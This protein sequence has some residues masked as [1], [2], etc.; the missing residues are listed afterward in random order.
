MESENEQN[1]VEEGEE[2]VLCFDVP[3]IHNGYILDYMTKHNNA[4][5]AQM[6]LDL[7][8]CHCDDRLTIVRSLSRL[9]KKREN[10]AKVRSPGGESTLLQFTDAEFVFPPP[11]KNRRFRLNIIIS[12][13]VVSSFHLLNT[14]HNGGGMRVASWRQII[15]KRS[16]VY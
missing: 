4:S 12:P 15:Y 5:T 8:L 7:P 6:L 13:I 14:L 2:E 1:T 9:K 16:F 3:Y 11:L 10:L